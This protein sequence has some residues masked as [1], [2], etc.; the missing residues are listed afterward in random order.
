MFTAVDDILYH[1]PYRWSQWCGES[2]LSALGR[3]SCS[4]VYNYYYSLDAHVVDSGVVASVFLLVS[5][6]SIVALWT[7]AVGLLRA[8]ARTILIVVPLAV[9]GFEVAVF[10]LLNYWW[11][12]H[13]TEFLAGTPVTNE[14]VFWV[15][16]AVLLFGVLVEGIVSRGSHVVRDGGVRP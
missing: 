3:S 8:L 15:S 7:P 10:F 5:A 13:A 6:A 4:L 1:T 12:V 11:T 14:V 2:G 9:C 16:L